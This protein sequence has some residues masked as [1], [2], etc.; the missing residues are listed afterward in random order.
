MNVSAH[1]HGCG[2][3][4]FDLYVRGEIPRA[5]DGSLV[6]A[7]SRR[8]KDRTVFSRWHDAQADL[9]R[10]DLYPGRPGRICAHVLSVDSTAANLCG[11]FFQESKPRS[12]LG[13]NSGS[14]N[15]KADYAPNHVTQPNHGVNVAGSTVWVTNLLFGAPLEVDLASWMPRR[16]LRY[17]DLNETATRTTS[18]SHFAWSLDGR[19]AY[20][21][22]SLLEQAS[23]KTLVRA[24]DL[25]LIR[26][27]T[28]TGA[29]HI[30]TL[31][32]PPGDCALESSNFHSGF[33]FEHGGR[34]Y[35]GL[36]RTGALL[37]S[38]TAHTIPVDHYVAPMPLSTIWIAELVD[39]KAA[40]QA[41]LLDGVTSNGLA[42]SHL[43][44]DAAGQDGF[45]LYAN[46]KEAPVGEETHGKN[47]YG[48]PPADVVE[49][50]PGMIV[51][52]LNYGTVMRYEWRGGKKSLKEFRR[53]YDPGQTALG[54]TWLPINIQLS[55][56]KQ[57]L[58]CTFSGLRP[59]LLSEHIAAAYPSRIAE[60]SD[61]SFVPPLLMRLN[62]ATL[63]PDFGGDRNHLSY[64]EP[65][66]MTVV[67]GDGA[68]YVC[69]FSPELGLRII[70]GDDLRRLICHGQSPNLM[71][72]RDSHFRPEPAHMEFVHR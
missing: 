69:T 25:R 28:R 37:E 64:A 35:V 4:A 14:K 70:L 62:A 51:E 30:W 60:Q 46:Y 39:E 26:I 63:E 36:L 29:E 53:P 47:I 42:L 22:Q 72:W 43:D 21:H 7:T 71:H 41:W 12:S 40:L 19:Y 45:V 20:F 32:A 23:R 55:S 61:V 27:D 67:G 2:T 56:D 13:M 57:R 11:E 10:L 18:T 38:L 31:I 66:A 17:V 5:F 9:M 8:A 33:Y 16:V 52:A 54:H 3:V 58:F 34:R 6:V 65:V 48:E 68:D 59:R 24:T 44:V 50:Y 1:D 49:H 15:D